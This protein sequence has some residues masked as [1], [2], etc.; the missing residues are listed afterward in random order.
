MGR[1]GERVRGAHKRCW[2]GEKDKNLRVGLDWLIGV[3]AGQA[4]R[5]R[6][7][8]A[9]MPAC[10]QLLLPDAAAAQRAVPC[11]GAVLLQRVRCCAGSRGGSQ[12][13]TV[14][15]P[16]CLPSATPSLS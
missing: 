2:L 12:A 6:G 15:P 3:G 5:Q 16:A 14:N 8:F 7:E 13:R 1:S 9:P 10:P 11:G 4:V